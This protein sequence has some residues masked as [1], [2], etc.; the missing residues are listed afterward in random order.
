MK[1][2]KFNHSISLINNKKHVLL[3]LNFLV[4][5]KIQTLLLIVFCTIANSQESPFYVGHSLISTVVPEMVHEL[6]LAGNKTTH[7]GFQIINGAPL[8]LNFRESDAAGA[9][10]TPYYEAFPN[11]NFN[12]L[13]VT[14]AVPLDNHL[15]W[16]NTYNSAN[17]FYQ[18]ARDN[19]NENPV[20]FYFYETWHCLNSGIP[21]DEE[22]KETGCSYDANS[23]NNSLLWHPRL[24]AD[25]SSWTGIVEHVRE[26]NRNDSENILMIPAGQAFYNLTTEINNGNLP[27]VTNIWDLFS[28]DIHPNIS[29]FYFVSCVVYATLFKESPVGLNANLSQ[30]PNMPTNEQIAVMQE[31]AWN[32]VSSLT[33]WTGVGNNPETPDT[34]TT[35]IYEEQIN[36]NMIEFEGTGGSGSINYESSNNPA[37]GSAFCVEMTNTGRYAFA[38]FK[39]KPGVPD[40]DLSDTDNLYFKFDVRVNHTGTMPDN[41]NL[42]VALFNQTS[43]NG[44]NGER[45]SVNLINNYYSAWNSNWTTVKVP[46]SALTDERPGN[47]VAFD[48]SAVNNFRIRHS[49]PAASGSAPPNLTIGIDNV[50]IIND[51]S[52]LYL[53]NFNGN[54]SNFTI[55]SPITKGKNI[56]IIGDTI[57]TVEIYNVTGQRINSMLTNGLNSVYI[58]SSQMASGLYIAIINKSHSKKFIVR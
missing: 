26:Q 44:A 8:W 4:M 2:L 15:E 20:K 32:T 45:V 29:G 53:N 47:G 49:W 55:N 14:E 50:A 51:T 22:G 34:Q 36:T 12:N 58:N 23:Q 48:W 1:N 57:N 10:G 56:H 52:T 38:G 43:T 21:Q 41:A 27:G 16:S 24:L 54:T 17:N 3:T 5:K 35:T 42:Q 19:N 46:L 18:Y 33:S 25:F 40:L 31:V 13:I 39:M 28:D 7:Y 6:A 37:N 11:G 30:Y 9:Q